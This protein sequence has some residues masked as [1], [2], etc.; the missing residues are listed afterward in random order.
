MLYPASITIS[1]N[2]CGLPRSTVTLMPTLWPAPLLQR[3]PRLPS[4]MLM[5]GCPGTSA[6]ND[7][8]F[9]HYRDTVLVGPAGAPPRT[10]ASTRATGCRP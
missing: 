8:S 3:V 6:P 4:T 5:S 1:E 10:A 7:D 2:V 9:H